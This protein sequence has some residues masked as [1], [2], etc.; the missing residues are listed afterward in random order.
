MR[1]DLPLIKIVRRPLIPVEGSWVDATPLLILLLLLVASFLLSHLRGGDQRAR[2]AIQFIALF[3]FVVFLHRCICAIR[4]WIFGL[5]LLGRSDL[6]A[7]GHFC[8][9]AILVGTA[10]LWGRLFCGWV[11]P[12][13]TV[14]ELVARPGLRRLSL[15]VRGLR[16]ASGLLSV[17][18]LALLLGWVIYIT[19]PA[20]HFFTENV[21]AV[22]AAFMLLLVGLAVVFEHKERALR[23]V[24]YLSLAGW[25]SLSAVGVFVTNPWCVWY[26]NELDFSSLA[27][28]L[29]VVGASAIVPL[30]WCRYLCPLG[31]LLSVASKV[32]PLRLKSPIA[33]KG[34][35]RCA[36]VCPAGALDMG[37][38]DHLACNYCGICRGACGFKWTTEPGKPVEELAPK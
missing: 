36:E 11:C 19:K 15:D 26:G 5:K 33:C 37:R 28:F 20:T 10:L 8:I 23:K 16:V 14:Q 9:F 27:A 7:F 12:L 17:L 6:L 32:A 3:V 38:V 24:R 2:R 4:G 21:A 34:C 13:G 30:S 25:I 31:A 29:A 18:G 35:G 22:W 1:F